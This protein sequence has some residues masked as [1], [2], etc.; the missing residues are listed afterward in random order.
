MKVE[1]SNCTIY[2]GC[3]A[4]ICLVGAMLAEQNDEWTESRRYMSPGILAVCRLTGKQ[5]ETG[6]ISVTID[7]I[8]A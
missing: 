1:R 7:A 8:G 5:A 4:I 6:E 2:T 3:D